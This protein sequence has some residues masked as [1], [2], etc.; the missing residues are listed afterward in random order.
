MARRRPHVTM[1][2][3]AMP[4]RRLV[5]LLVVVTLAAGGAAAYARDEPTEV[6]EDAAAPPS[7][8]G[9]SKDESKPKDETAAEAESP[10]AA[11]QAADVDAKAATGT[12]GF[13]DRLFVRTPEDEV[14]LFPGARVQVDGAAVSR[15]TPKSGAYI[16]RA[17][18]E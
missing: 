10:T 15:Q 17:R 7:R 6:E 3:P 18:I 16:R 11:A 14:V 12:V 2:E 4:V 8:D 13:S 1:A 9:K 5:S